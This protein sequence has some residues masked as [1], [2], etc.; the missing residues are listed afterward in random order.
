MATSEAG[1]QDGDRPGAASRTVAFF[2]AVP[3]FSSFDRIGDPSLFVPLPDD[4]SIGVADVVS[5]TAAIAKGRYKAVN[6]AGASVISALSNV[7]GTLD[8]PYLF[9]GDGA[10]FAVA[11]HDAA[12][13]A[14]T[15][16]A[17]VTWVGHQLALDLR[18]GLVSVAEIRRHG[19]DVRIARFAASPDAT[20]ALF[21]GGGLRW[22][23][24]QL[25]AGHLVLPAAPADARPD[26]TGLSCRFQDLRTRHG[27]ILSVL[28]RPV[29]DPADRRFRALLETVLGITAS[30]PDASRPISLTDPALVISLKPTGLNATIHRRPGE[31]RMRSVVRTGIT[32]SL[33]AVLFAVRRTFRGFSPRRYLAEVAAN[34]DFRKY[35]DGLMMTI[36]CSLAIADELERH[37]AAAD[38]QGIARFGL[39]RQGS[40]T[41]TC[42]VPSAYKA[43]H[44]HFVDGAAGGY[45]M[46]A[47]SLKSQ[48]APLEGV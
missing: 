20:Y 23:E 39:H 8:F 44:V 48:L 26:L 28:I 6:L 12:Q 33:M 14:A 34:T 22:A 24:E 46:A 2:E 19:H 17:T 13:A 32:L 5:S 43:N 3:T 41:V 38:R 21:T 27:V 25:K 18:G 9:A 45:A 29:V 31:R 15:L 1:S 40:A 7:L 16:A 10:S 35:D 36:D 37:L 47:R 11:G 42:V 4:W 30:A